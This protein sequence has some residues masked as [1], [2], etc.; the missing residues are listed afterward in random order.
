[1][2][3][4]SNVSRWVRHPIGFWSRTLTKAE[5]NYSVGEKE[6]LAIVW[7]VQ[8]LRPY[9][10]RSHFELYTDHIALKLMMNLTDASGRLARWRLRLLEFEFTVQ[11]K[12]GLRT[13]SR[14]VFRGFRLSM[15]LRKFLM[16]PSRDLAFST[17]LGF[18]GSTSLSRS[19]I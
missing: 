10:E 15:R 13:L 9:L 6:C 1:M 19:P 7:E 8:I 18:P 4:P 14:I 17:T 5:R 16:Q 11:Y 3:P 2:Y 12:K